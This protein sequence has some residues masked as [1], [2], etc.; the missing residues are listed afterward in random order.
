MAGSYIELAAG[1]R[2]HGLMHGAPTLNIDG[3]RVP[4]P[5]GLRLV[6]LQG[7]GEMTYEELKK[8]MEAFHLGK[9]SKDE[10]GCA[11]HMWQRAKGAPG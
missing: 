5:F 2:D 3:W 9:I 7:E 6:I 8:Y 1:Y 11:I 10:L 4:Y